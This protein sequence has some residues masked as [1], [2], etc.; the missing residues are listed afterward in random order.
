MEVPGLDQVELYKMFTRRNI[1]ALCLQ[2]LRSVPDFKYLVEHEI[3][4]GK[5]IELAWRMDTN[6]D[7]IW[8]DDDVYGEPR[9]WAV[10]CG[11]ALKKVSHT[12]TVVVQQLILCFSDSSHSTRSSFRAAS[13]DTC[14]LEG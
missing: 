5:T 14:Y 10:L 2:S 1:I 13:S 11:L 12:T 7:W 4:E 9:Y 6:L 3:T 8:L